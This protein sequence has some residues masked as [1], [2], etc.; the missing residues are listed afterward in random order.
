MNL[1]TTAK[2][3]LAVVLLGAMG[4]FAWGFTKHEHFGSVEFAVVLLMAMLSARMKV[5][6]PGITG[7][8]CGNLPFIM[9][10]VVGFGWLEALVIGCGSTLVQCLWSSQRKLNHPSKVVFNAA[11]IS[12]AVAMALWV[13]HWG[14]DTVPVHALMLAAS[15][16]TFFV[17]G[18]VPVA[19]MIAI[20]EARNAARVGYE[21]A[22]W[23]FPYYVLGA[24]L[25][26]LVLGVNASIGWQLPLAILPVA[27]FVYRAYKLY[28][29][30]GLAARSRSMAAH[31]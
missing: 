23:T 11:N 21:M 30:S 22:Q 20:T 24:G 17:C 26:S 25:T 7:N 16:A 14:A 27:Y 3:L 5:R 8:L 2:A 4:C 10:G 12:N 6:I 31:A 13:R 1:S 18:I 9:L 28:A 29:A 19:L 15:V